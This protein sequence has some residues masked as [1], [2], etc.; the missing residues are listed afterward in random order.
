VSYQPSDTGLGDLIHHHQNGYPVNPETGAQP[1]VRPV[2]FRRKIILQPYALTLPKESNPPKNLMEKLMQEE[3]LLQ[4]QQLV[5]AVEVHPLKI[6]YSVVSDEILEPPMSPSGSESHDGFVLVSQDEL[7]I[8]T[9]Q[10]L[11]K[12]AA[13]Q[14]ASSCVRVWSQRV[15]IHT[16]HYE[17]VHLEDLEI[18]DGAPLG[19]SAAASVDIRKRQMTVGEWLSTHMSDPSYT[20]LKVLVE[21][22]KNSVSPW[23]REEV[24]LENRIKVRTSSCSPHLDPYCW[25]AFADIV[26]FSI[27]RLETLSM[28]RIVLANGLNPLCVKLRKIK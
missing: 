23:P 5:P 10:S 26:F 4:A 3:Q 27:F 1:A 16:R 17:M 14:K 22:R 21:T 12:A 25:Q 19:E 20:Q 6:C 28:R 15:V 9:L 24:E 18:L 13:P 7:V 2:E 11:M 8:N